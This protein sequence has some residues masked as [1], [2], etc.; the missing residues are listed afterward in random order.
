[1]LTEVSKKPTISNT[2]VPAKLQTPTPSISH[3]SQKETTK[4]KL[5]PSGSLKSVEEKPKASGKLSW[6]KAKPKGAKEQPTTEATVKLE[7]ASPEQP[8]SNSQKVRVLVDF[9]Q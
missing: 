7:E 6:A 5:K 4:P 2:T 8:R 3:P 1:M 9:C